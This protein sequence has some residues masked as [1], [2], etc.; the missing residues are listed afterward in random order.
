M[1]I[2]LVNRSTTLP[3][4]V[5]VVMLTRVG[6]FIYPVDFLVLETKRVATVTNHLSF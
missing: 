3:R 1:V 6:E 5:V 2:S 4:G